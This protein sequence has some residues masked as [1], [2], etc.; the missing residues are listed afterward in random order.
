MSLSEF[1][2]W[3]REV[4]RSACEEALHDENFVPDP[5]DDGGGNRFRT[6]YI[7]LSKWP[8]MYRLLDVPLG[9]LPDVLYWS[10]MKIVFLHPWL[11]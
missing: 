1:H 5:I 8:C 4:V 10:Q 7:R 9:G 11:V 6:I 2:E 3:V